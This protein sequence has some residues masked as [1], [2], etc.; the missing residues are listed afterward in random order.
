MPVEGVLT[1]GGSHSRRSWGVARGD[2]TLVAGR[3]TLRVGVLAAG[4]VVGGPAWVVSPAAVV[5]G[6]SGAVLV[7]EAVQTDGALVVVCMRGVVGPVDEAGSTEDVAAVDL[8]RGVGV[9]GGVG[10]CEFVEADAAFGGVV[11]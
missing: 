6:V 8:D 9:G 11:A 3:L 7:K 10:L 1:R 4:R 5:G 2:L